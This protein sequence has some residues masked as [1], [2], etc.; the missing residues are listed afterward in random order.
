MDKG[1]EKQRLVNKDTA[2]ESVK[3]IF[4]PFQAWEA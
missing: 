1:D 2:V 3:S 4:S